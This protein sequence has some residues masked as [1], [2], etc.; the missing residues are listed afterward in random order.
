MESAREHFINVENMPEKQ[1]RRSVFL[2]YA[3]AVLCLIWVLYSVDFSALV[4]SVSTLN[5]KLVTLA[6]LL[7]VFSYAVQGWRWSLLLRSNGK[8][9]V[10]Q[11][12]K[13]IYA[14]LFVNEVLPFK[15]GEAFRAFLAAKNLQ[16]NVLKILPTIIAERFFD[17]FWLVVGIAAAAFF[18]SLP[19][20]LIEADEILGGG[21]YFDDRHRFSDCQTLEKAGKIDQRK[22]NNGR[23]TNDSAKQYGE[24][25]C[26]NRRTDSRGFNAKGK[27]CS[28]WSVA[29]FAFPAS[30]IVLADNP[31]LPHRNFACRRT[32]RFFDR[33]NRFGDSRRASQCRELPIFYGFRINSVRS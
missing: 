22:S 20:N 14:G 2:G 10:F 12:T 7:D 9:S 4:S 32:D 13:A 17:T 18:V 28:I 30:R 5:L 1:P 16:T 15:L 29:R 8:I 33:P 6:I 21:H 23:K 27:S 11:A 26:R 25:F 24:N 3:F 19:A 31:R